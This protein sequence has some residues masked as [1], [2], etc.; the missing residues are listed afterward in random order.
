MRPSPGH[1]AAPPTPTRYLIRSAGKP[2]PR[3]RVPRAGDSEGRC[4]RSQPRRPSLP[5]QS[6]RSKRSKS[7]KGSK[8]SKGSNVQGTGESERVAALVIGDGWGTGG[9]FAALTVMGDRG[10]LR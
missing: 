5:P 3:C 1:A 6:K 4:L 8:G 2:V 10:A 9:L 7:S